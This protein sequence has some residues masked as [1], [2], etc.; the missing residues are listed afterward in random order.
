MTLEEIEKMFGGCPPEGVDLEDEAA[1]ACLLF[2]GCA[3]LADAY[4]EPVL[5]CLK[6]A[7]IGL[8]IECA[9]P[10]NMLASQRAKDFAE[11]YRA[12]TGYKSSRFYA[13]IKRFDS[14]GILCECLKGCDDD[15]TSKPLPCVEGIPA[16]PKK[17]KAC[18][19][20]KGRCGCH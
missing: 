13:K 3:G 7:V 15:E 19:G 9:N 18:C 10:A 17:G 14:L 1:C 16:P 5:A 11:T 8:F 2:D 6:K 20:A 4:P 12:W